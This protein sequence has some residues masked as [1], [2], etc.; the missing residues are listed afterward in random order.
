MIW[1]F[2]RTPRRDLREWNDDWKVGDTAECIASRGCWI[3]WKPWQI[4]AKG[5]RFTITGFRE[6]EGRDRNGLSCLCYYLGFAEVEGWY[7]TQGFRKVRPIASEDS[8]IV[9]RILNAKP[10]ADNLRE[11][12]DHSARHIT[13]PLEAP[14]H[15]AECDLWLRSDE[16]CLHMPPQTAVPSGSAVS[17]RAS[18]TARPVPVV[19]VPHSTASSLEGP[20]NH[21]A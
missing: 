19:G 13:Q 2:R 20:D 12:V 4:L 8:E 18:S 5:Q 14:A 9:T 7:P 17:R 21:A 11:P 15:C 1:P 3:N 6:G 16:S 10:G